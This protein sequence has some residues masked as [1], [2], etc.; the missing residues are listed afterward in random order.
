MP[1]GG[2]TLSFGTLTRWKSAANPALSGAHLLQQRRTN[3]YGLRGQNSGPGVNR[4]WT[5][6]AS[7]VTLF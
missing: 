6:Y 4:L 1:I 5:P 7:F 3:Q 2:E